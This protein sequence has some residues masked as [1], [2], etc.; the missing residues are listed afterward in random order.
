MSATYQYIS[1]FRKL[2]KMYNIQY[3]MKHITDLLT[4]VYPAQCNDYIMLRH[5]NYK[6]P[7]DAEMYPLVKYLIDNNL[8]LGGW[9]YRSDDDMCFFSIMTD[10]Y[11][12][13]FPSAQNIVKTLKNIMGSDIV[14]VHTGY[15]TESLNIGLLHVHLMNDEQTFVTVDFHYTLVDFLKS[16]LNLA[17]GYGTLLPG[18]KRL[19]E[20]GLIDFDS[21][22]KLRMSVSNTSVDPDEIYQIPRKRKSDVLAKS[23]I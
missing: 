1:L 14:S 15:E 7:T 10:K 11:H 16:V 12:N 21:L 9:N 17:P 4:S 13:K 8:P 20:H 18:C 23:S 3:S 2:H 6:I 22:E 5:N 19:Y